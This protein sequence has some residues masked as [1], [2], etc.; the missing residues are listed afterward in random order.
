VT[1]ADPGEPRP[2]APPPDRPLVN[3][4]VRLNAYRKAVRQGS[5]KA[6][7]Y[8]GDNRSELFDLAA[9]PGERHDLAADRPD[10]RRR[11]L[12]ALYGEVDLLSGGW[13]LVWSSDG[14]ARRFQG[15]ITTTGIFRSIVP[16]FPERGTDR[17]R[18]HLVFNDASPGKVTAFTV[19]PYESTVT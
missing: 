3:E 16:L 18:P 6:I 13:N 7:L 14:R 17:G 9:D 15:R 4:T 11:L 2:A 19:A 8:M 10:D 1:R 12:R 5:L